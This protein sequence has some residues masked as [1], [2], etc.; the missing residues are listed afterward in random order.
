[1]VEDDVFDYQLCAFC[2]EKSLGLPH[3]KLTKWLQRNWMELPIEGGGYYACSKCKCM[4]NRFIKTPG[5]EQSVAVCAFCGCESPRLEKK[6]LSRW[7]ETD[8]ARLPMK[9]DQYACPGCKAII[10]ICLAESSGREHRT[11]K[12]LKTACSRLGR[13][14]LENDDIETLA[15]TIL[16]GISDR[17]IPD[18]QTALEAALL[19]NL[20]HLIKEHKSG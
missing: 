2:E 17:L 20:K 6:A 18:R 4:L 16:V 14:V 5:E 3:G 10:G 8:W 9:G 7:L 19:R 13:A 15:N 11:A 12:I 1:M